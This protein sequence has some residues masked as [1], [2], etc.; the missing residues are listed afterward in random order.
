MPTCRRVRSLR[1]PK[2]VNA[3]R[4]PLRHRGHIHQRITA[5]E[6]PE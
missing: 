3:L 5:D 1:Q 2:P 4:I 6:D